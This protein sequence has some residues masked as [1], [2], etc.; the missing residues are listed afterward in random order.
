MTVTIPSLQ[1]HGGY[2]GNTI[3]ANIPDTC[4]VC[5]GPRGEVFET[6]SYDGSRRLGVSGWNNPCGHIDRYANVR[7]EIRIAVIDKEIDDMQNSERD[8]VNGK[9]I[10]KLSD[11]WRVLKTELEKEYEASRPTTNQ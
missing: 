7:K 9:L 3:T 1:E 10:R 5:G 11:E 4:P 8:F 2:P 6:L